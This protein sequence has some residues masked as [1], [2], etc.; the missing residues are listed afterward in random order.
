MDSYLN[1]ISLALAIAALVP[2]LLPSTRVRLWTVTAVGLSLVVLLAAYQTYQ[3]ITEQRNIEIVKEEIWGLLTKHKKGLTFE[4][5][6]ENLYYRD[7]SVANQALDAL[8]EEGRALNEKRETKDQEGTKYVVRRY[9][10][11]FGD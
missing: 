11:R 9:F 8:V 2:V 5:I 6:Y 4:Q 3:A 7:F 1:I 10:R